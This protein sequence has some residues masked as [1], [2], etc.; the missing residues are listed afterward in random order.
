MKKY[1]YLIA[2]IGILAGNQGFRKNPKADEPKRV[3]LIVAIAKFKNQYGENE[4]WGNLSSLRDDTII[5]D[6]LTKQGFDKIIH[7]QNE[8][9]TLQGIRDGFA[10][11][12]ASVNPGDVVYIHFSGHGQQ[13]WDDS[14]NG[15]IDELDGLDECIVTYDAPMR[16]H[17]G[18]K[19]EKHLRDDELSTLINGIRGKVGAD[20][21][22]W[23]VSDACH[24]GTM[25]RGNRCRGT[26]SPMT[27]PGF[28]PLKIQ[29]ST[30]GS[31]D[32]FLGAQADLSP[33]VLFSACQAKETN[34]EHD[35]YGSLSFA[36]YQSLNLIKTGDTYNTLFA[37]V[38][39]RMASWKLG[40][41][42]MV[43]G[44]VNNGV[45]GGE[46]VKQSNYY[47]V[48]YV[49]TGILVV[50]G[51]T[52][53]GLYVG[54]KVAVMP[55]GSTEYKEDRVIYSGTVT[56]AENGKAWVGL[57]KDLSNY[58]PEQLWVFVTEQ[59]YGSIKLKVGFDDSFK[60]DKKAVKNNIQK[61]QFIE[62]T[63][64]NPEVLINQE[65]GKYFLSL[66]DGR[67]PFE[68][69]DA[70]TALNQDLTNYMQGKLMAE[71]NFNDP[72]L[73][74]ELSFIPS[75]FDGYA[76]QDPIITPVP[77][78]SRLFNGNLE[79]IDDDVMQL[80][81]SN[82]GMYDVYVNILEIAPNGAVSVVLPDYENEDE[83]LDFYLPAGKTQIVEGL[84]RRLRV[85]YG[86]YIYKVFATR[87][88]IDF[89]MIAKTR[90]SGEET[91]THPATKIFGQSFSQ[92]RSGEN[93]KVSKTSG[94]GTTTEY[95][96]RLKPGK[97]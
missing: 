90:G 34:Q 5:T 93:L 94:G 39:A 67:K 89:K 70:Y 80:K 30:D 43:E 21:D 95:T 56:A 96:V 4:Q 37:Y 36:I 6:A 63:E 52:L 16:Y 79:L 49:K 29:N 59:A 48:K 9:A 78:S 82:T 10:K 88:K 77:M 71:A 86:K 66:L 91:Y 51:G 65:K 55:A 20:G 83:P 84:F 53:S 27:P 58:T 22:V 40:Q 7:V 50:Q 68:Q 72:D 17:K 60:G 14:T 73:R 8:Q 44:N 41:V 45:F 92:T 24:S 87:E 85:D 3:A 42:P 25:L 75:H 1:L 33:V 61:L 46:P 57:D 62:W 19:G 54:S 13:L 23:V 28:D 32:E 81:L 38:N 26:E 76:G 69:R 15:K 31:L 64:K 97:K 2:I 35:D 11:L 18:Y 47:H 74:V 12:K